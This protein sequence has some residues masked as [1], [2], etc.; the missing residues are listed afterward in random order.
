MENFESKKLDRFK[1]RP[2]EAKKA[3]RKWVLLSGSFIVGL[4]FLIYFFVI[5]SASPPPPAAP[6]ASMTSTSQEPQL[7]TIEGEVKERSNFFQSLTEKNIPPRWI[8]LIVSKL[9]SY[10][11]FRKIKG[12]TYR[13]IADGKGELVKFI[14]EASPTEIY[15]IEKEA[16]G[17]VVRRQE[18]S[19]ETHLVKVVGEIRSSLFEAMDAAGEQDPL[20]IA[21]AEILAWEIDFYKDI[22]EGDRFKVVVE[23]IYKGDQFVGYGTIHS[24]E[25][26]RGEKII[27]GIHYKDGYYNEKGISLR[28][29]F[30]KAPLRFNRISSKFSRARLHPILGG[31][32][33]HLGVDYAAPPGTPIW[34][35]A[36][37]TVTFCGWGDGFG[38]QVILR[39]RNGYTT[40]YGHLSGFCPGIRKG[41]KVR[42]KQVIGYVGSTGL[43]TGPHLDYRVSRDGRF[44]NPVKVV[45]PA[46]LPIEKAEIETFHQRRDQM[47]VWLQGESPFWKKMEKGEMTIERAE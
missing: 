2:S 40:Y 21:F 10:V 41:A 14:Y 46:G 32:R 47:L 11:N 23:K 33:A 12:G 20:T 29:G 34:A 5:P 37:G 35:V 3:R 27:R 31:L 8:D 4:F 1:G 15:E 44:R 42:Q 25:Y 6:P 22:R 38:N 26:Q 39:H 24:V 36:D 30:L 13:F 16:Q 7:Q 17:Y 45:F 43:S 19:L 18:V 9:K 28:K